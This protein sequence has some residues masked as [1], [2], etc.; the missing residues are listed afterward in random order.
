[1]TIASSFRLVTKV[2]LIRQLKKNISVLEQYG[3]TEDILT[4]VT[5][6]ILKVYRNKNVFKTLQYFIYII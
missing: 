3:S 6:S 4:V 5:V 1:M 2:L